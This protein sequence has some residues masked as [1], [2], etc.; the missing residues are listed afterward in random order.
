MGLTLINSLRI[1]EICINLVLGSC[2]IVSSKEELTLPAR[3]NK[4]KEEEHPFGHA[5]T[6][7]VH[8][9]VIDLCV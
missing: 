3:I 7:C 2:Y 1:S 6:V 8:E 5:V 4:A 9:V